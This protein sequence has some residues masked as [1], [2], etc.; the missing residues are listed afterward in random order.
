MLPRPKHSGLSRR[1]KFQHGVVNK[2]LMKRTRNGHQARS[3]RTWSVSQLSQPHGQ[4]TSNTLL[5][6]SRRRRLWRPAT[7]WSLSHASVPASSHLHKPRISGDI[8]CHNG[9]QP[10]LCTIRHGWSLAAEHTSRNS[11][12]VDP[13]KRRHVAFWHL[14]DI[15]ANQR[16]GR[17]RGLSGHQPAPLGIAWP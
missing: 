15:R 3:Q 2:R 9:R 7:R 1:N 8:I 16:F 10:T 5:G 17:Y 13:E 4:A 6:P 12:R 11:H 14:A